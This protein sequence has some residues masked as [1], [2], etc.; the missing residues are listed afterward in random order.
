M[1]VC[2]FGYPPFYVDPAN[3]SVAEENEAIYA[4]IAQGFQPF[5]GKTQEM[6]FGP[7]FP[8]HI[9][10]SKE[11]RDLMIKLMHSDVHTRLT[12]WEALSHPWFTKFRGGAT[13]KESI[14]SMSSISSA[15][16][17]SMPELPSIAC[18]SSRGMSSEPSF[19]ESESRD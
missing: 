15:E 2:L 10:V 8:D 11:A 5:V 18:E 14:S 13:K 12:A 1:F 7:W 17:D 16:F 19:E 6:G 9:P 4:K 3:M